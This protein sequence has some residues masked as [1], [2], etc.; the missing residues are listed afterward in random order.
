MWVYGAGVGHSAGVGVG[1]SAC[2]SVGTGVSV[3]VAGTPISV[4]Q[5]VV[6]SWQ[7]LQRVEESPGLVADAEV[8]VVARGVARAAGQRNR[9][10]LHHPLTHAYQILAIMRVV[11]PEIVARK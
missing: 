4:S 1:H 7:E 5:V 11:R 6:R 3:G 2:V 9:L 10:S 8:Q